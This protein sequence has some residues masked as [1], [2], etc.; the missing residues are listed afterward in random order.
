[1]GGPLA[2]TLVHAEPA[3]LYTGEPQIKISQAAY[4]SRPT[5]DH[6]GPPQRLCRVPSWLPEVPDSLRKPLD[7]V[8]SHKSQSPRQPRPV[9]EYAE[10]PAGHTRRGKASLSLFGRKGSRENPSHP[11]SLVP[12]TASLLPATWAPHVLWGHSDAKAHLS[13]S[14][15]AG[16]DAASQA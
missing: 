11:H 8:L 3:K 4:P 2:L 6:P 9:G 1:M 10:G 15:R 13:C 12:G 5:R 7:R 16:V 14:T